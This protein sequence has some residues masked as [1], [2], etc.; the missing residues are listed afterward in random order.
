VENENGEIGVSVVTSSTGIA[1][2]K[3]MAYGLVKRYSGTAVMVMNKVIPQDG[4][5]KK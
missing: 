3:P 1:M 5:R 4:P 2:L